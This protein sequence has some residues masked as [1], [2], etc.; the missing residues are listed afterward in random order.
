MSNLNLNVNVSDEEITS[1]IKSFSAIKDFE[2]RRQVILLSQSLSCKYSS[3]L[4]SKIQHYNEYLPSVNI[5]KVNKGIEVAKEYHG[6]QTRKSGELYYSH[7]IETACLFIDY[8]AHNKPA[9]Y[10]TDLV[11]IALLHDTI[12]DTELT[13]DMI[14]SMFNERVAN[15]V[16]DLT[17]IKPEGKI[18]AGECA[19]RLYE[20]NKLDLGYVKIFDRLHN[21]QTLEHKEE[22]KR[23]KTVKENGEFFIFLAQKLGMEDIAHELKRLN[24]QA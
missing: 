3:K 5:D 7:P 14:A 1:L 19:Q 11:N 16:E 23:W 9:Y 2:V 15:G 4:I 8:V 13:K 22:A 24:N 6:D 21:T 18:S 17:R 10:T 12:E 20:E